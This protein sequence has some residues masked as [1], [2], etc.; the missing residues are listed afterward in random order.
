MNAWAWLYRCYDILWRKRI[1]LL[2]PVLTMPLISYHDSTARTQ[3]TKSI[4]SRIIFAP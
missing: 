4:L 1:Y 2:I 3:P